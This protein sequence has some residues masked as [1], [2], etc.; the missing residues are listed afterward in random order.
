MIEEKIGWTMFDSCLIPKIQAIF[1]PFDP[2][3]A[4]W[5]LINAAQTTVVVMS[6]MFH[7]FMGRIQRFTRNPAVFW[8]AFLGLKHKLLC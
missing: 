5:M 6:V 2:G 8:D 1:A 4:A 7:H 3:L